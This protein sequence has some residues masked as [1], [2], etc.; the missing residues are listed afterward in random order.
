MLVNFLEVKDTEFEVCNVNVN[1]E[2][3]TYN[4][5]VGFFK[6]VQSFCQP[7]S[8][9]AS[10]ANVC[11]LIYSISSDKALESINKNFHLLNKYKKIII[12][13]E[14]QDF[15]CCSLERFNALRDEL[16][17]KLNEFEIEAVYFDFKYKSQ[18]D[19]GL[20]RYYHFGTINYLFELNFNYI[21]KYDYNREK[22][23]YFYS[24]N[25]AER[26][27]RFHLQKYLT[28]NNLLHNNQVSFFIYSD[29]N[30][31]EYNESVEG[32]GEFDKIKDFT[33]KKIE[34]ETTS[35]LSEYT[36]LLEFNASP[37]ALAEIS[38][39][40]LSKSYGDYV[41]QFSEKSFKPFFYKRPFMLFGYKNN[42]ECLKELGYKTFDFI[43]DESYS[44]IDGQQQRL[45]SIFKNIGNFCEKPIEENLELINKHSDIYNYNLDN[46]KNF[47]VTNKENLRYEII[48]YR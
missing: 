42:I 23:K 7:I 19:L 16:H 29:K 32:Y 5:R 28:D 9:L 12:F 43:F 4:N 6:W 2:E 11:V 38:I 24:G 8:F 15:I 31:I 25:A 47:I 45:N 37:D 27:P 30:I 10:N 40:T 46:L 18:Y 14:E 44:E 3:Y 39:E 20:K 22:T 48:S 34:F 41:I 26:A 21:D 17:S 33:F 13:Q 35:N 1:F 36:R